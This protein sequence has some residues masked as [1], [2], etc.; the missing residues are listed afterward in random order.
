MVVVAIAVI[1]YYP[2]LK[3][4]MNHARYFQLSVGQVDYY[5]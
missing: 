3:Q 1:E 5:Y 2:Q 4:A